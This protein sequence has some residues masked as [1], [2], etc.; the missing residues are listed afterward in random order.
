[1][2]VPARDEA[3]SVGACVKSVRKALRWSGADGRI[4]VVADCCSDETAALAREAVG[5]DGEVVISRVGRAGA[6]RRLGA[7]RLLTADGTDPARTWLATTDAD[8]IVPPDWL[9]TQLALADAGA[10]AVAGIVVLDDAADDLVAAR[11]R[12]TYAL[13]ADGTHPHVHGANLGVRGD[14]YLDAG[15]WCRDLCVGEDHRMW[16]RLKERR[17]PVVSATCSWVTTSSRPESRVDGGFASDLRALGVR[18]TADA[19]LGIAG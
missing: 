9:R 14:A 2:V 16:A 3:R 17:W 15:G 10:A 4:V 12:A 5:G 7:A 13:H 18:A 19:P 6:A 1:M 8:G 11:H